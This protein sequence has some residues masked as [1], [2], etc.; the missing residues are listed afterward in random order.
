MSG[1]HG[2]SSGMLTRLLMC[3]QDRQQANQ[4][5]TRSEFRRDTPI[6][7]CTTTSSTTGHGLNC[8]DCSCQMRDPKA[9]GPMT[10]ARN[11]IA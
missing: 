9:R 4:R 8:S 6:E 5:K 1:R 7:I 11:S 3:R 10:L 2:R